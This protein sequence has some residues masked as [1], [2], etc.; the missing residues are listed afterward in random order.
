VEDEL[1]QETVILVLNLQ[2]KMEDQVAELVETVAI[3]EEE[4]QV[5]ATMAD[6]K[7]LVKAGA[8]EELVMLDQ[9]DQAVQLEEMVET[10][11][12]TLV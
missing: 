4:H 9:M 3:L 1:G 10:V 2:L 11:L 8:V 7:V 12:P 5:K 6:K